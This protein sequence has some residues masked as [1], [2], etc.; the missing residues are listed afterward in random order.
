MTK[1]VRAYILCNPTFYCEGWR[2]HMDGSGA[3]LPTIEEVELD[4]HTNHGARD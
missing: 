2:C 4:T 3:A 1:S